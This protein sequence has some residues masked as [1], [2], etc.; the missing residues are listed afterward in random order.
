[1]HP[2]AAE[3]RRDD[4]NVR[5]RFRLDVERVAIEDDEVG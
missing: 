5:Q 2:A 3:H 4:A 1:V